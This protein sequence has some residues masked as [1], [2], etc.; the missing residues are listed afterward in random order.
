MLAL[1][2]GGSRMSHAHTVKE[3][4]PLLITKRGGVMQEMPEVATR[5][6]PCLG[7]ALAEKGGAGAI[8]LHKIY[9][10]KLYCA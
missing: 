1:S 7:N 9:A 10:M 6:F 2:N 3:K 4:P 8:S 5:T